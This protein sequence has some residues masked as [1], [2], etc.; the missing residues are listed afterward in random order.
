LTSGFEVFIDK[1]P[2]TWPLTS[3]LDKWPWVGRLVLSWT[4]GIELDDWYYVGRLVLRWTSWEAMPQAGF[5][6]ISSV[7]SQSVSAVKFYQLNRLVSSVFL[8][9]FD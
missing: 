8:D 5:P 4:I 2:W 3:G 7:V 6:K 1:H 9:Q